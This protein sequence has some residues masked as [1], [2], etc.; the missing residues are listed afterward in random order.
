MII[1][2]SSRKH[3]RG[4]KERLN[5]SF[6]RF[7]I[8]REWE[9]REMR[10]GGKHAMVM[11]DVMRACPRNASTARAHNLEANS[12]KDSRT[13]KWPYTCAN[14][15]EQELFADGVHLNI[16]GRVRSPCNIVYNLDF[17]L[18]RG[19]SPAT[20]CCCAR[21]ISDKIRIISNVLE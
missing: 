8:P 7:L 4:I 14:T 13:R 12:W 1:L 21:F 18:Y 2:S 3:T 15:R 5:V 9:G 16:N 11:E 19:Y 10:K 6:A 20:A 17:A